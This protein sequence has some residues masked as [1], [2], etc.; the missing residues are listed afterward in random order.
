[1]S[2]QQNAI[3]ACFVP[4]PNC[5]PP[6]PMC[7]TMN[8]PPMKCGESPCSPPLLCAPI[9]FPKECVK[10]PI[11]GK[12][13]P[14]GPCWYDTPCVENQGCCKFNTRKAIKWQFQVFFSYLN[15]HSRTCHAREIKFCPVSDEL[16]ST[17]LL[18]P[19]TFQES[20][21]VKHL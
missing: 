16:K 1:M 5:P 7:Y 13:G 18:I 12:V 20:T 19:S 17:Y 6:S 9:W 8:C 15:R 2:C 14:Y 4:K 11:C 3:V 10:P 21:K